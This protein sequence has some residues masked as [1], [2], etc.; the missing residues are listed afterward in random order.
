MWQGAVEVAGV[1]VDDAQ[2][3]VNCRELADGVRRRHFQ[4]FAV[5]AKGVIEMPQE[6]G[7]WLLRR[8]RLPESLVRDE[9]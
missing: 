2:G 5:L 6:L 8:A 4:G 3:V 1:A 7:R 9:A